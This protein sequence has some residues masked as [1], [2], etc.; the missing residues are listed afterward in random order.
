MIRKTDPE[1]L[2]F[3]ST[4]RVKKIIDPLQGSTKNFIFVI[5]VSEIL[6]QL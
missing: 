6:T 3:E 2:N 1:V 4:R 5:L